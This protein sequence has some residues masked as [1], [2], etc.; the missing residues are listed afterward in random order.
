MAVIP[1]TGEEHTHSFG[2]A[3]KSDGT[4]HWKECACG[5]KDDFEPHTP[6]EW[7]IDLAAT[8]M[9]DGSKHKECT[10]CGYT[11]VTEVIPATGAEHTHVFGSAWLKDAS[12]HW[13]VCACGVKGSFAA[14]VLGDWIV[15]VAATTTTAGSKHKECTVC[16]FTTATEEIPATGERH[17]HSFGSAWLKNATGHWYEC[18]CGEKGSFATHTPG[19]WIVD[20]AATATKAGSKHKECTVCAFTTVTEVIPASGENHTH[21]FG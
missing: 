20:I 14:H 12:G 15:D 13:H 6:G 19:N 18:T 8:A 1:A 7:I 16:G 17:I 21:S 4:L 3:W 2:N 9:A 5:E 11:V 10:V